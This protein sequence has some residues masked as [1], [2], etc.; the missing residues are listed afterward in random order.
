MGG[1]DTE[2][3]ADESAKWRGEKMEELASDEE[4]ETAGVAGESGM[5]MAATAEASEGS[6]AEYGPGCAAAG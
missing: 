1:S 4:A 5:T 3:S 6:G 2:E